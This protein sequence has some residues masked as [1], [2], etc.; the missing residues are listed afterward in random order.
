MSKP[1][2]FRQCGHF[3]LKYFATVSVSIVP[4]D[5]LLQQLGERG[6][7]DEEYVGLNEQDM[8]CSVKMTQNNVFE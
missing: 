2:V 3:L 4:S 1:Y 8:Q 5:L 7:W 6:H